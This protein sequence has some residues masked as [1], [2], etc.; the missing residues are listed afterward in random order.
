MA[1]IPFTGS[2][3]GSGAFTIDDDLLTRD[4]VAGE[5]RLQKPFPYPELERW[6]RETLT[7]TAQIEALETR[8]RTVVLY[9]HEADMGSMFFDLTGVTKED[10]EGYYNH[11]EKAIV[12]D[13][14]LSVAIQ[15]K[16]LVVLELMAQKVP[17]SH[18]NLIKTRIDSSSFAHRVPGMCA[19]VYL[20]ALLLEELEAL[21]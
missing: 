11:R 10:L 18:I 3:A 21:A 20:T 16:E 9:A 8:C 12:A 15:T 7:A 19:A 6:R 5:L 14:K 2:G 1:T 17:V 4:P 13:R